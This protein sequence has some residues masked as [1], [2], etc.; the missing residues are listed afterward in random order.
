VR[1][2]FLGHACHLVE[3]GTHR[4]VTD[5]W[6][7][8]PIF[9]G[10]VERDPTLAFGVAD[11]PPVD[12]IALTHG[13]LDHFNAPSLAAFPDKAVPVIVPTS[14][15]TELEANL[16]RL[17]YADIRS[18]E[19]WASCEI[20]RDLR[21]TATPS[22]GVLDE[23]AYMFE[24]GNLRFWNGADAPQPPDV[25][26]EIAA[27]FGAVDLAALSHNS[28]DQPALLSLDSLKDADH[29]PAAA[30]AAART[31]GARFVIPA[32]S[33]MRW[34][35][36]DGPRITAKVIRRGAADLESAIARDAP[37]SRLLDLAPGDAWSKEGGIERAALRGSA[38]AAVGND[39]IHAF[40]DTGERHC[41]PERPSSEEAARV[42]FP[43]RLRAV[44]EAAE[45]VRANVAWEV[46]GDD[47][48]TFSV[49]FVRAADGISDE[50]AAAPF[51][52]R[53]RDDDWKDLFE[54]RTSWQC[55]LV[56]DRLAV[57][58]YRAGTPPEGLHF[59][60]AMQAIFP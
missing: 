49:D 50:P 11:L 53:I 3:T 29:G 23:C 4:I 10:A 36:G 34:R 48:V 24:S 40:L 22:L 15:W 46:V 18:L 25:V 19:D 32:A 1:V 31:L 39:Y 55:L 57:T 9:S 21:V 12:A 54:R 17:G 33:N 52:L 16:R 60:Y 20:A 47:A 43:A 51:G 45:Y 26:G 30:A 58:R 14:G 27:R 44:A 8:D 28:F 37:D 35:G 2:T 13:H 6:L 56:S 42:H 38:P 41:G 59:A 7:T 5:P